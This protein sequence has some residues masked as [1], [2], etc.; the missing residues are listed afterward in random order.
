MTAFPMAAVIAG[1]KSGSDRWREFTVGRPPDVLPS[2]EIVESPMKHL[3]HEAS[4]RQRRFAGRM[5]L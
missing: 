4:L 3:Y 5:F 2:D 1:P